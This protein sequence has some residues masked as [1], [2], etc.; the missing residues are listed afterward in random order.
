MPTA[1]HELSVAAIKYYHAIKV[2]N[3]SLSYHEQN[4]AKDMTKAAKRLDKYMTE[5]GLDDLASE[6]WHYQSDACHSTIGSGLNFW[7]AV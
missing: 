1:M 2:R 5:A 4:Y 7:S 6:W 3:Q